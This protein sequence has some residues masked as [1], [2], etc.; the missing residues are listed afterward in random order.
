MEAR[1]NIDTPQTDRPS[2]RVIEGLVFLPA[3]SGE[4]AAH[5]GFNRERLGPAAEQ[6]ASRKHRSHVVGDVCSDRRETLG[7]FGVVSG[8]QVVRDDMGR[9]REP[10]YGKLGENAPLARNPLGENNVESRDTVG[11]DHKDS[12]ITDGVDITHFAP[13]MEGQAVNGGLENNRGGAQG[14]NTF[15]SIS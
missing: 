1:R 7:D 8:D 4:L 6:T 12:I 5:D 2:I 14:F 11:R 15:P 3:R 9:L 13:R 10:E